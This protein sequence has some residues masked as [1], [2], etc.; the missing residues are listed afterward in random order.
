MSHSTIGLG[1]RLASAWILLLLC[2]CV[3]PSTGDCPPVNEESFCATQQASYDSTQYI[4]IFD[5]SV[6]CE[7][8]RQDILRAQALGARV[9]R[10]CGCGMFLMGISPDIDPNEHFASAQTQLE[11]TG[12]GDG[13]GSG[14]TRNYRFSVDVKGYDQQDFF[15]DSLEKRPKIIPNPVIVGM[16]DMGLEFSHPDLMPYLWINPMPNS[17]CFIGD[18]YS[19]NAYVN[20]G[21]DIYDAFGHGTH[22]GGILT[23][24]STQS[25]ALDYN[26][27]AKERLRLMSV[28]IT[29][30]NT[31]ETDLFAAVCGIKYAISHGADVLNLSWGYYAPEPDP[32]LASV[33][34]EA[35]QAGV[36]VI[37]S[38]GN[39]GVST[40]RCRHW[41]SGFSALKGYEHVLSVAALDSTGESL[42][43]FSNYGEN[44]VQVAAPGTEVNST[45]IGHGCNKLTG[46][47]MSAPL[48]ARYAA[49][50][51]L[52]EPDRDMA[53]IKAQLLTNL[54]PLGAPGAKSPDQKIPLTNDLICP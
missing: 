47:S 11:H 18:D 15:R 28:K 33:L 49:M 16:V 1:T 4:I 36:L 22:V 23:L 17:N 31:T 14:F 42:A 30:G 40:D 44:T 25:G 20:N 7:D 38:A 32:L 54:L 24:P 9:L 37:A 48:V 34:K 51:M 27:A 53:G 12:G 35:K 26:E 3:D 29:K 2:S 21:T 10:Q 50:L 13:N 6:S 8:Q 19:Y 45:F 46:T 5:D 52:A 39:D 43:C 41:P